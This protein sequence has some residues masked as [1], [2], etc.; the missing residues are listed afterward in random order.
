MRGN[1]DICYRYYTR[2]SHRARDDVW[3]GAVDSTQAATSLPV[4]I[5]GRRMACQ[6]DIHAAALKAAK[7]SNASDDLD[8]RNEIADLAQLNHENIVRILCFTSGVMEAGATEPSWMLVMDYCDSD[9]EKISGLK[10]SDDVQFRTDKLMLELLAQTAK[11]MEYIHDH[12][13]TH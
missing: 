11:G 2:F 6:S 12:G 5:V 9:L 4:S 13:K 1:R 7:P 8:F 10:K 3:P